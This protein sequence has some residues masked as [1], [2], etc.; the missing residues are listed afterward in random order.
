MRT[1]VLESIVVVNIV[2]GAVTVVVL[3]ATSATVLVVCQNRRNKMEH[4]FIYWLQ[5]FKTAPS[6]PNPILLVLR[7]CCREICSRRRRRRFATIKKTGELESHQNAAA[8]RKVC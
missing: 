6:N 5:R 4:R 8:C 3:V 7:L 2:A 1:V